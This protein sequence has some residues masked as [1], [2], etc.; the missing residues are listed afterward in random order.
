[1]LQNYN[2][3]K[4]LKVFFEDPLKEGGFQLR[5]LSRK[6][7][8]A[9][10]SVKLYLNELVK[11]NLIKKS[12]LH[13]YPIYQANRDNEKFLLFKKIDTIILIKEF[14]LIDYLNDKCLPSV[15]ILFGSASKGEDLKDSDIDIF[16]QAK[17]SKLDLQEFETK[18]K[19]KIN[20]FFSD[21]FNNLS[22]EL[23]NNML[24]GIILKG[25]LKVF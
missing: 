25:Y 15:I 10:I 14:N 22:K 16:V 20:I 2:K 11:D 7:K 5:E 24:N 1:M 17:E 23:K 12:T 18:L 21:N 6:I 13:N 19:R 4:L 8:L 3:W 9:P